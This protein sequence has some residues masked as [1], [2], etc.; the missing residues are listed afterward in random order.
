MCKSVSRRVLTCDAK[1]FMLARCAEQV[2][3]V[4]RTKANDVMVARTAMH[5]V[6]RPRIVLDPPDEPLRA[7]LDLT[8]TILARHGTSGELVSTFRGRVQHDSDLVQPARQLVLH[9][10]DERL[11]AGAGAP[12]RFA[13]A[14]Q[15]EAEL[16]RAACLGIWC[17]CYALGERRTAWEI[18][19]EG[20][21]EGGLEDGQ[22]GLEVALGRRRDVWVV[23][24]ASC[25]YVVVALS[26][27][28]NSN[29]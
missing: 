3:D 1:R 8:D 2:E 27:R 12:E 10:S 24:E 15:G 17:R 6:S 18:R 28:R 19:R 20:D 22:S 21:G 23:R 5:D 26:K 14:A 13:H 11:R 16:S 4:E 25:T 9:T 7:P 29:A